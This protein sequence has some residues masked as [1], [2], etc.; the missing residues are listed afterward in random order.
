MKIGKFRISNTWLVIIII[1]LIIVGYY[2]IRQLFKNPLDAYEIEKI[3]KGEVL[4]EIS[5][6]GSVVATQD[7]SLGFKTIGRV[8]SINVAVGDDVKKGDVLANLDSS[9]IAAQLE[10]ARAALDVANQ[11][12]NKLLNGSAPEDIKIYEDAVASAQHDLESAYQDA[13]DALEITYTKI[14]NAYNVVL[15]AQNSYFSASDQ[16]GIIVSQAKNDIY[17][18]MHDA[19]ILL[20]KAQA[21][22]SQSDIDSALS[23]TAIILDNISNDLRVIREQCDQTTYYSAV[24]STDKSSL[25][26]QKSY[27]NTEAAN[28]TSSRQT[29]NSYKIILQKAEDNLTSQTAVPRQEDIG[30]YKSQIEQAKANVNLYQSQFGDSSL[31]SPVDGKITRVDIKRG[32]TISPGVSVISLLSSEPFQIKVDVYEQDIVN[33]KI[34]NNV[35][36]DLVAFPKQTFTGKVLSVDPAETI[37]DNVV[38]YKVTI[39]FPEQPEGIKSGMTADVVIETNKKEDVVRVPKSVVQSINGVDNVQVIN[40]KKIENR[41]ITTGL[42]GNDYYEVISGLNEG[43]E[44]VLGNK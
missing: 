36:I 31:G 10:N 16:Q 3:T 25:D 32:E 23:Q 13:L 21:S 1:I 33:V 27:I 34:G 30:I 22:R 2:G 38:Y 11:Q 19:R 18:N 43:D 24:S 8:S 29:V 15:S 5:E 26:T 41:E 12:Y 20:D 42:E 44:I 28:T 17:E 6:T 4:Q 37:V 14:Y 7:I 35:K 9:Q 39:D 40:R